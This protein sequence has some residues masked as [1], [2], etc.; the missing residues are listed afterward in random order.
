MS[1]SAPQLSSVTDFLAIA[2]KALHDV[3]KRSPL[4]NMTK[5]KSVPLKKNNG[6]NEIL[7]LATNSDTPDTTKLLPDYSIVPM[8]Q[9]PLSECK[10]DLDRLLKNAQNKYRE[11]G[12][13]TLHIA[14]GTI[15]Y[16]E[17]A[18]DGLDINAPLILLRIRLKTNKNSA[19]ADYRVERHGLA[20]VNP[21]LIRIMQEKAH[22]SGNNQHIN[23]VQ[24]YLTESDEASAD[25]VSSCKTIQDLD[26]HLKNLEQRL[27]PLM[28]QAVINTDT[29]SI[30]NFTFT[31]D[32]IIRDIDNIIELL[33]T[34]PTTSIGSLQH[35]LATP[36]APA[37]SPWWPGM[38]ATMRKWLKMPGFRESDQ[39]HD[40]ITPFLILNS[41]SSQRAVIERALNGES[42]CVQGPP[43]TGKSQTIANLI[44]VCMANH[45]RMLFVAEKPAA[46]AAVTKHIEG[47]KDQCL[48]ITDAMPKSRLVKQE[49]KISIPT[50]T[51]TPFTISDSSYGTWKKHLDQAQTLARTIR[52]LTIINRMHQRQPINDALNAVFTPQNAHQTILWQT[53]LWPIVNAAWS[54][55][56]FG[57]WGFWKI[58]GYWYARLFLGERAWN[59]FPSDLEST[60]QFEQKIREIP[61]GLR[62]LTRFLYDLH[63][64]RHL[65]GVTIRDMVAYHIERLYI[66]QQMRAH[67]TQFT[68][69]ENQFSSTGS[70][71]GRAY[72][73]GINPKAVKLVQDASKHRSRTNQPPTK[74]DNRY[75]VP[76]VIVTP[77]ELARFF[78]DLSMKFDMII[79]DEASQLRPESAI[80]AFFRA[81]Q[82]V[83]F[84]DEKQLPP[85]SFGT[86]NRDD[87][88]DDLDEVNAFKK[89][90]AT[91]GEST[92][93]WAAKSRYPHAH[94]ASSANTSTSTSQLPMLE[95]YYRG[96]EQLISAS[97]QAF[98]GGNIKSF[99]RPVDSPVKHHLIA[100][101]R[102][103]KDVNAAI[104]DKVYELYQ[105]AREHN[106]TVLIIASGDN[107]KKD[108]TQ[109]INSKHKNSSVL[110]DN[111]IASI[112]GVQGNQA[113]W[114][115][116]F[117]DH[118]EFKSDGTINLIKLG[119]INNPG[120]ERR[121]NVAFTRAEDEMHIVTSFSANQIAPSQGNIAQQFLK[122][123]IQTANQA[124]HGAGRQHSATGQSRSQYVNAWE[125]HFAVVLHDMLHDT[126]GITVTHSFGTSN[127]PI[128]WVIE[129]T[130]NTHAAFDTDLGRFAHPE[131]DLRD[132][133]IRHG[134]F[135]RFGWNKERN[136][137]QDF[138]D[139]YNCL[140]DLEGV[141]NKLVASVKH[142]A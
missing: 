93:T 86:S 80:G 83:V 49:E 63:N 47:L 22:D 6:I 44:A 90:Y 9:Q 138:I 21:A 78:T 2:S 23:D 126:H 51:Q 124:V 98:Y 57:M 101:N 20:Y 70:E 84:G 29:V 106:D 72:A 132:E 36:P 45:K 140:T 95:F 41:D 123:F 31:N 16:Q 27:Q 1:I 43:G 76:C 74:L 69:L 30:A 38:L 53:H 118:P 25:A 59:H 110:D 54:F 108:F 62:G 64:N 135:T 34:D 133:L 104:F 24:K 33:K 97:N 141:K 39:Q 103:T 10:A 50:D 40:R 19:N 71:W 66:H 60:T 142:Q 137:R 131:F 77:T 87:G 37:H 107:P 105:H 100:A 134:Q 8:L 120:G 91:T 136:N 35:L 42:L 15:Q 94:G 52:G 115:I 102:S 12:F 13:H 85:T 121:L 128:T 17:S 5:T 88:E 116:F 65:N 32:T 139:V 89:L 46:I 82:Y 125:Q 55:K 14:F 113:K 75:R 56:Y 3:S 112:E 99:P 73:A 109:Y 48:H 4:V 81:N 79:I 117:F 127:Q 92:L 28:Q 68:K 129:G 130:Q 61:V 114:V 18:K 58:W 26:S 11:K 67:K 122:S 119:P 96:S 7:S 111:D